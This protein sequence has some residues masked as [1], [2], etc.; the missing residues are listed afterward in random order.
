MTASH[1]WKAG[2]AYKKANSGILPYHIK[3][4][5]YHFFILD[6][7]K[8]FECQHDTSKIILSKNMTA[9]FSNL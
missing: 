7:F 2:S 1:P 4:V 9:S 3:H 8:M 5:W 6:F